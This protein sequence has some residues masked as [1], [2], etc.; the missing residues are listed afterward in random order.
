MSTNQINLS[1]SVN[2]TQSI[3]QALAKLPFEQVADTWFKVKN[4][5]EQQL[6]AQQAQEQGAGAASTEVGG[7][8]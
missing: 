7:T 8:D 2:E 1:L 5:A 6:A 3:L 4:Q